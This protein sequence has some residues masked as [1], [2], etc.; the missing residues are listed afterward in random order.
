MEECMVCTVYNRRFTWREFNER[1]NRLANA[2][3]DL[4]VKKGELVGI[5]MENNHVYFECYYAM[6]KVGIIPVPLNFRW[7]SKELKYALDQSDVIGLVL[8]TKFK[9]SIDDILPEIP[10]VKIIIG[11]GEFLEG[12]YSYEQLLEKSISS[13]PDVEINEDDLCFLIYT[14]GTTGFPKAAMIHHKNIMNTIIDT[15][16]TMATQDPNWAVIEDFSTL[17]ILPAFHISVWPVFLLHFIGGKVIV[18]NRPTEWAFLLDIIQTEKVK[19]IN[20]VPTIYYYLLN[21]PD[22]KKYDISSLKMLTYA[23]APFPISQLKD[24][25]NILSSKF[26]QGLGATEGLP[27]TMLF[28][29]DHDLN[30]PKNLTRICSCGRETLLSQVKICA[31]NGEEVPI[32]EIGDLVVKTKSMMSGYWKDPVKTGEVMKDGWYWTG[33]LGRMDEYGYVYLVDRKADMIKSGGERVYPF[34]VENVLYQHPGIEEVV[35]V[36]APDRKWGQRVHAVI[37]LRNEYNKKYKGRP[38]ELEKELIDFCHRHLTAY[39]CPK[40]FD[41]RRT[42]LPKTLVGKPL[43]SAIKKELEKKELK[44]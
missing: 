4:G 11:V 6:A 9:K 33:D 14:G 18:S 43:R 20:A 22:I 7:N 2:L 32:G 3:I 25:I 5:L 8:E 39:K 40:S 24:C 26:A 28:T 17:F 36:G 19:H 37:R 42:S 30:N 41:F 1:I 27:W 38:Q 12:T 15:L 29:F 10:K 34:E 23:G 13:E 31:E 35:V 44:K 21:F 16:I